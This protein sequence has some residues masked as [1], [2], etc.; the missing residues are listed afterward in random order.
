MSVPQ[1]VAQS[2]Y[3]FQEENDELIAKLLHVK[4]GIAWR[5]HVSIALVPTDYAP[6]SVVE[7]STQSDEEE[8]RDGSMFS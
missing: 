8:P 6:L 7:E 1:L 4:P 5:H 3:P 2:S